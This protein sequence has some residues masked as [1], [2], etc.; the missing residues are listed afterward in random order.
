VY[1]NSHV[2][3]KVDSLR[4]KERERP[5]LR[6]DLGPAGSDDNAMSYY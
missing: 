5:E 3:E 2:K 4:I 1:L 6:S